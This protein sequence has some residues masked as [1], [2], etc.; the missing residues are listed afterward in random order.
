MGNVKNRRFQLGLVRFLPGF[1]RN[2]HREP[3]NTATKGF[4]LE[5][6][7][8]TGLVFGL[9]SVSRQFQLVEAISGVGKRNIR[10]AYRGFYCLQAALYR[11]NSIPLSCLSLSIIV[12]PRGFCYAASALA[13]ITLIN[14]LRAPVHA[15][16]ASFGA[17]FFRV[18]EANPV[19]LWLSWNPSRST[20]KVSTL[21]AP[22]YHPTGGWLK[23]GLPAGPTIGTRI[24]G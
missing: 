15:D 1:Y 14:G 7:R 3:L 11:T 24:P 12:T 19:E 8:S 13:S 17:N 21:A 16:C 10:F 23:T 20:K 2:T 5:P 22:C 6:Q 9:K 18:F 4:G